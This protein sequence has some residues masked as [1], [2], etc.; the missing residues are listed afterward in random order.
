MVVAGRRK[1]PSGEV[2]TPNKLTCY[3]SD[4]E[5]G[6]PGGFNSLI[7]PSS[8]HPGG[9]NVTCCDGSVRFVKDSVNLQ[10]WWAI[11]TRNQ[12]EIVSADAY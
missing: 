7:A 9:V 11:G 2:N 1:V 3:T 8:N 12:G 6:A 10:V 4:G 5:G